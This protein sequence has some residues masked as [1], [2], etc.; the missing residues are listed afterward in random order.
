MEYYTH[1][2]DGYIPELVPVQDGD[3]MLV[4]TYHDTDNADLHSR[5]DQDDARWNGYV[6]WCET[7]PISVHCTLKSAK[8]ALERFA[9]SNKY[10][11]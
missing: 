11:V 5:F 6:F 3:G 1:A 8:A 7:Q 9:R 4:I 2:V 10:Y